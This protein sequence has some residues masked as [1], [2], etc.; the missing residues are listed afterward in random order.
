MILHYFPKICNGTYLEIGAMDGMGL[1]NTYLLNN[2]F[3][4]KGV[5][6]EGSP[7]NYVKLVKNRPRE[8]LVRNNV[9][10]AGNETLHYAVTPRKGGDGTEGAVHGIYEFMEPW[11]KDM[12]HDKNPDFKL[13]EVTCAP[14]HKILNDANVKFIDVFSLDVEG[15]E[16]SV[17]KTIDF[18][19]ISFG[20]IFFEDL[21][22]RVGIDANGTKYESVRSIL[23]SKGYIFVETFADSH[24]M[25]NENFMDIYRHLLPPDGW[26]KM[27]LLR[28]I[29]ILVHA[30]KSIE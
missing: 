10:C 7:Y 17:V 6:V 9:I 8:I 28:L 13:I 15:A 3:D 21:K 16:L 24:W 27:G 23:E 30:K 20:L 4:W 25:I 22:E 19:K 26:K 12:F 14:L 1:S 5:L 2:H 11:Y 18:D 29:K